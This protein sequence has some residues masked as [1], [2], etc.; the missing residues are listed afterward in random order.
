M[1]GERSRAIVIDLAARESSS[2]S[3][4]P[5]PLELHS[6]LSCPALDD[7]TTR[8]STNQP[9][10]HFNGKSKQAKLKAV[11]APPT[12]TAPRIKMASS[13]CLPTSIDIHP[14]ALTLAL[15]LSTHGHHKG[16]LSPSGSLAAFFI[17]YLSLA[18]P[19][20]TFGVV[21]IAFYLA[22]SRATKVRADLKGGWEREEQEVGEGEGKKVQKHKSETGGGRDAWQVLSNGL[23][24]ERRGHGGQVVAVRRL[25]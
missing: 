10:N 18:N 14:L 22:G 21:L 15:L 16:S 23:T 7:F 13:L 20:P 3:R 24:G 12:T 2:H 8:L 1:K 11:A 17:G 9:T 4:R 19:N 5:P 25:C 6:A